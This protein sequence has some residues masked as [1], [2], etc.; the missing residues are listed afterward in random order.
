MRF[1][2]RPSLIA[3]IRDRTDDAAWRE[4]MVSYQ[5]F[6]RRIGADA[7]VPP[8]TL[9]DMTQDV[10]L[11]VVRQL[12]QFVY[13][14]ARGRFRAWLARVVRSR[15]CD[16][17]RRRRRELAARRAHT[18]VDRDGGR[19][20]SGEQADIETLQLALARV[21]SWVRP[22]TW[23]CFERHVLEGRRAAD[24]A[25]EI[26]VSENAVYLNSMRVFRR[27]EA[28]CAMPTMPEPRNETT[29]LSR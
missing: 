29:S 3:R 28:E 13:D 19:G 22:T 11:T 26:G 10:F 6:I 24:V 17:S 12:P 18:P 21:R 9:A 4:F 5:P 23:Q 16:L 14:P 25:R 27:I 8:G 20:F 1:R 7:G 2:T 15:C